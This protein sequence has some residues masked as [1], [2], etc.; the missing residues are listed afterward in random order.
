MEDSPTEDPS[1]SKLTEART[2]ISNNSSVP[3][4]R[5]AHPCPAPAVTRPESVPVPADR[6]GRQ[7]K[8]PEDFE[9]LLER[10][11]HGRLFVGLYVGNSSRDNFELPRNYTSKFTT[12]S[13]SDHSQRE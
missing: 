2:S 1:P 5:A 6:D 10:V 12:T 3:S 13:G 11:H 9:E 8:P 7:S 4:A